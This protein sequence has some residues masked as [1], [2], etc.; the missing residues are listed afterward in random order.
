MKNKQDTLY[1]ELELLLFFYLHSN[2]KMIIQ[3]IKYQHHQFTI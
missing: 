2:Y 1:E 3:N